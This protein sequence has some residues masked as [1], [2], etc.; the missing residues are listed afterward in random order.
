MAK[1]FQ[2]RRV[3][4]WTPK[5]VSSS[6]SKEVVII[7]TTTPS[8][9]CAI[10][11]SKHLRG[12]YTGLTTTLRGGVCC[13]LCAEGETGWD[14]GMC[15]WWHHWWILEA[16]ADSG[17]WLCSPFSYTQPWS[18]SLPPWAIRTPGFW[19]SFSQKWPV[20]ERCLRNWSLLCRM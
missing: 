16:A 1:P 11:S 6:P 12:V 9:L 19:I 10:L 2:T 5:L 20:A 14:F 13:S 17:V 7:T 4:F 15:P 18:I 3:G 8:L